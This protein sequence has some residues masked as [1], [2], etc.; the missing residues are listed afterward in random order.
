MNP[1][2]ALDTRHVPVVVPASL[3]LRLRA[4]F[5][6]MLTHTHT[7]SGRADHGGTVTP[8]QSYERLVAWAGRH[9]IDLVGMGSPYTP[10]S[11]SHHQRY[12]GAQ[13]DHYYAQP[14]LAATLLAQDTQEVARMLGEINAI[15]RR[16]AAS[17][18]GAGSGAGGASGVTHFYLDNET[19]KGRY[20]HLWWLGHQ[21]DAPSWHDYDQPFDRWMLHDSAPGGTPGAGDDEPMPYERRPYRHIVARQRAAGALAIWAHP[22]SWWH[23]GDGRFITN[24]ATEM[25]AH[26]FADGM[27]DGMVI[28]GY[29]ADRPEYVNLWL[30]LLD[31]G[32]RVPGLAEMD[33]GLSMPKLDQRAQLLLSYPRRHEP[34]DRLCGAVDAVRR[35]DV[36][37]SSGPMIDLRVDGMAMGSVVPT[38]AGMTHRVELMVAAREPGAPLDCVELLGREGRVLW[39]ARSVEPGVLKVTIGGSDVPD[40]VVARVREEPAEAGRRA[41]GVAITSPVYLHPRGCGQGFAAPM[42]TRLRLRAGG[43]SPWRHARV[44]FQDAAGGPIEQGTLGAHGIDV[45]LPASA[46]FVLT[47]DEGRVQSHQLINANPRLQ[48][49][50]RYLYRGR[51]LN[52]FAGLSAGE[53]PVEAWRLD[54]FRAALHELQI[55]V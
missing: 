51:F 11:S 22:T 34:S 3:H 19:P 49:L 41:C 23:D 4:R 45:T 18:A 10:V 9:H 35:G 8:P 33:M 39:S 13:R 37:V 25:P 20:G 38:A 54:E 12:D 14:D 44:S 42:T 55:E 6:A 27:L 47:T 52:D 40:Y 5:W 2:S 50:Q 29:Q 7:F 48:A 53:A 17:G 21:P 36:M 28:M 26:A 43:D 31:R 32:V 1:S 46:R 24:L 30:A 16:A 15:A